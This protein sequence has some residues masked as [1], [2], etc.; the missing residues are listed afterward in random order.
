MK[1]SGIRKRGRIVRV[2]IVLGRLK[3]KFVGI[4]LRKSRGR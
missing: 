2:L 3:L 4:K 1:F